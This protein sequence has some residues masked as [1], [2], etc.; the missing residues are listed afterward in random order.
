M[1]ALSMQTA[2]FARMEGSQILR[3]LFEHIPGVFF[4]IK[5]AEG[6]HITANSAILRRYGIKEEQEL[7][8]ALAE[9]FF[10]SEIAKAYSEDDQKVINSGKPIIDRLE[11]W[12]DEQHQLD[13]FLTTKLPLRNKRGEIIGVVG[14]IRRDGERMRQH[15]V[16]EVS[17]AVQYARQHCKSHITTTDLARAAGV[18]ERHLN[19]QVQKSLGISPYELVLRIRIQSAAE[20]LAKTSVAI[21][22]IAQN[23]GFCDQ[24]AFSQQFKKRTGM[25]PR[26][27]RL[28][29]Q[30]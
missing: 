28:S 25:T 30:V 19:R 6:R 7:V 1:S 23:H 27:F 13:W 14:I 9:D 26:Q 22:D 4:F 16:S 5:D 11:L 10:P 29:N 15:D 2:F 3:E 18:S 12:Y 8:G 20:A 17:T 21:I 24:S